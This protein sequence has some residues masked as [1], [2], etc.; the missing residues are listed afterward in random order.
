MHVLIL[1]M[2]EMIVCIKKT[3]SLPR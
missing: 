3:Q 1:V 2:E